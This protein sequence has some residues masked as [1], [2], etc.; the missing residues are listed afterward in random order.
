MSERLEGKVVLISGAASG[1]GHA[2]ALRFAAEGAR[3]SLCDLS[4]D[5]V[6]E[7]ADEARK[8]GAEVHARSGVDLTDPEQASAWVDEAAERFGRIDVLYN[9][10]GTNAVGP[11]DQMPD[12]VWSKSMASELETTHNVTKAV[13]PH[14]VNAGGGSIINTATVIV[15]HPTGVPM[16]VHGAAKG[17]VRSLTTHLAVEGG[18][19]GIRVNAISPGLTRTPQVAPLLEAQD[20]ERARNQVRTS[21]LGR[22][23]EPEDVANL[24]LFLASD[25]ASY[26]TG[27][28]YIVDGG[29]SL[30]M[31][32]T[33][34]AR[35]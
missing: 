26:V 8:A 13:W 29:Q 24:A 15:S 1:I 35:G 21:P 20:D 9:N 7:V 12:D 17:A 28:N 25:E 5:N 27:A 33:F 3:L 6:E 11:F 22:I 14:L 30:A 16:A 4:E 32:L 34:E 31:G 18:P 19:S 10:A 23:G 2:S